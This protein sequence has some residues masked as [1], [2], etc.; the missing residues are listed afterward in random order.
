MVE[1]ITKFLDP[2]LD[3]FA[4]LGGYEGAE[5]EIYKAETGAEWLATLMEL[6]IDWISKGYINRGLKALGAVIAGG[7][8]LF[9]KKLPPRLR[10]ELTSIGNHLLTRAVYVSPRVK[11]GEEEKLFA[12]ALARG[13][14]NTALRLAF[15]TPEELKLFLEDVLPFLKKKAPLA[16]AEEAIEEVVIKEEKPTPEEEV[17]LI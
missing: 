4:K 7:L 14:W 2:V 13:D 12:E 6:G 8:G 15:R 17:V 1:S 11:L 5:A 3:F 9:N 16:P 10:R